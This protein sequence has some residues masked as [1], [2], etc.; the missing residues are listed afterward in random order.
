M[1]AAALARPRVVR[2]PVVQPPVG[3]AIL[4]LHGCVTH[5]G[6]Y[7][8]QQVRAL[9]ALVLVQGHFVV[10][11]INP[12]RRP[13]VDARVHAPAVLR[14]RVVAARMITRARPAARRGERVRIHK[15]RNAQIAAIDGRLGSHLRRLEQDDKRR[16]DH[17]RQPHER[18]AMARLRDPEGRRLAKLLHEIVTCIIR[19]QLDDR[20]LRVEV[21]NTA[22][23]LIDVLTTDRC[24]VQHR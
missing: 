9:A 17:Q 5:A 14:S 12:R 7:T 15:F 13:A 3:D 18:V 6:A 19:S 4:E 2:P 22:G 8:A 23:L 21:K 10:A 20:D 11:R 16:V 24:I 1:A